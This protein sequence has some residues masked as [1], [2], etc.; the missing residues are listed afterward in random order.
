MTD[1]MARPTRPDGGDGAQRSRRRVAGADPVKRVQILDGAREV[2][3]SRGFDAASM[4]EIA[5]C[6]N[7]S[8]GTLYEIGRAHV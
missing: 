1:K 8:K 5:S 4:S 7:V 3:S 6:A 2:F